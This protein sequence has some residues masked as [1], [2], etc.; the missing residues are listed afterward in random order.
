MKQTKSSSILEHFLILPDPRRENHNTKK[1]KLIDIIVI[2]ILAVICGADDW[3]TVVGFGQK[4]EKW[5]RQFMELPHGIPS[6]DTFGRV[7]ALLDPVAFQTCFFSWV[8]AAH[9]KTKGQVVAVDGKTNRRAHGKASDPLHIVTAFA[10]ANGV[11]LGQLATSRKSNEI[12][13]VPKLLKLLD[14]AGCIVT[15]DAMS[16]QKKI[17]KT[18]LEQGADYVLAVKGNQ[19][20]LQKDLKRLFTYDH[21]QN[22]KNVQNDYCESSDKDHGRTEIRQC[23]TLSDPR[24]LQTIGVSRQDWLGLKSIAQVTCQRTER[25]RTTSATRYISS[26]AG[27]ARQILKAVREHW[28][29]ENNLH[30][31][32]DV[33]FREDDSR[34]RIGHAQENLAAVRKLALTLLRKEKSGQGSIKSRRLQAGWDEDYL[35]AVVGIRP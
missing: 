22:L 5:L 10:T 11:V 28:Q 13:A 20:M 18:I 21:R 4:K 9:R 7:F 16:C 6:H 19:Q 32:L 12:T 3:P 29:I 27:N 23:F 25:G 33:S 35:L 2:T 15:A 8:R 17:V 31:S 24:L 30:W 26:L 1:H 14:L 34:V